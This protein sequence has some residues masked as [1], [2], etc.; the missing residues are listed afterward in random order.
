LKDLGVSL[1]WLIV[2]DM[3]LSISN[4]PRAKSKSDLYDTTGLSEKRCCCLRGSSRMDKPKQAG[5]FSPTSIHSCFLPIPTCQ[6][7]QNLQDGFRHKSTAWWSAHLVSAL[8]V[9]PLCLRPTKLQV[10]GSSQEPAGTNRH[11]LSGLSRLNRR[12]DGASHA[13]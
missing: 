6:P 7:I 10:L 12:A 11:L 4:M 1:G 13:P 2:Y 8:F 3:F 9:G 5:L